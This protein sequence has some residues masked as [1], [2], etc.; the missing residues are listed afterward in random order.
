MKK[1]MMS[2]A[3]FVFFVSMATVASATQKYTTAATTVLGGVSYSPST[4]VGLSTTATATAW[5]AAAKHESGGT[6]MYGMTSADTN[7]SIKTDMDKAAGVTSQTSATAL[8]GF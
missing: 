3:A 6:T 4:G 1:V 8:T 5:A 7:I 2:A